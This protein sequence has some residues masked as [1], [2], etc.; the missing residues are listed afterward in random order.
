[1]RK[2]HLLSL[3][4]AGLLI[5]SCSSAPPEE[6][7]EKSSSTQRERELPVDP[8]AVAKLG[9]KVGWL[10][11]MGL[12][13]QDLDGQRPYIGFVQVHDDIIVS[14]DPIRYVIQAHDV[15]TGRPLWHKAHAPRTLDHGLFQPG[16]F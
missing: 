16:L 12:P 11:H 9:Y 2:P 7:T 5:A 1:M 14:H 15:R 3:A 8:Q 10:S 13:V 4:A 6:N